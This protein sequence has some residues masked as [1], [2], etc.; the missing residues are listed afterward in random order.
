MN[1]TLSEIS[2]AVSGKIISGVPGLVIRNITTASNI[3]KGDDLFIPVKG[4]RTDGHKY[5]ASAF[6]GGAAASFVSDRSAAGDL[7]GYADKGIIEVSDTVA[8]LQRFAAYYR[9]KYVKI[10]YIGVTG[11]V[12]KTTTREMITYAL[13]GGLKTYSTKGNANSQVGVPITVTETDPEAQIGVIEL[14]I[15]EFG[16]MEKISALAACDT[17]VMTVIGISHLA[18]FGSRENI[19]KEKLRIL[20]GSDKDTVLFVNGDDDI[21]KEL[22][23]EMIHGFGIAVGRKIDVRYFGTGSNSSIKAENISKVRGCPQ[24]DCV[25]GEK[26][27]RVCLSV[28]GDHM[29]LNALCAMAAADLYNVPLEAAAAKLSGFTGFEGRG[30]LV[31]I[32][33]ADCINDCYNASPQS[34]KS[35]LFVLKD[36]PCRGRKF[37]VLASMLEL[38]PDERRY[39]R[40]TGELINSS[41]PELDFLYTYG[42]LAKLIAEEVHGK[43][44]VK[45]FGELSALKAELESELSEGDLV[46]L[47]GSNS[48]ELSKLL[49]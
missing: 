3:I 47:K 24:F 25:I 26:R 45:V 42:D 12:G 19:L 4:A 15:S 16:E 44:K 18:Q 46:L 37:A 5:I 28:P 30:N 36:T 9:K 29:V 23:E 21:L 32:G 1:I 43:T 2:S 31:K 8:A 7:T 22:T 38:G 39:H 13:S 33:P 17:C 34:M 27:T 20:S 11:S 40:E 48:M 6:D 41:F 14:G 35:G 49:S 10:P